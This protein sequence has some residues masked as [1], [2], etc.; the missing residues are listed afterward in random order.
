VCGIAGIWSN[1][2]A[3]ECKLLRQMTDSL[4]HRGPDG[5]G[6]WVSDDGSVGL[7]HR[8]LSIIDLSENGAQPMHYGE[9][10]VITFNGEIYNYLELKNELEQKGFIFK[11]ESDTEVLLAAY[12][13][14]GE[15]CLQHLDGMF[16]FAVYDKAKKELFCARDRFGEKPFYYTFYCGNFYFASEMKAFWAVGVPKIIK[17]S[18]VYNFL[19]NDMVENPNNQS[20]TFYENVFKLK[21]SSFFVYK[22]ID[23]QQKTY[24][25]IN[26]ED[27]EDIGFEE[28]AEKFRDLFN[29][30]VKR[31][32]RSDVQVGSSLS[33]GLDS[34]SVVCAVSKHS[35]TNHTFSARFRDFDKDEGKYIE[36]V[37]NFFHTNHHDVVVEASMLQANLKELLY[38]QEEPFPTGSIFA[39]FKV[40]EAARR[41]N[42]LVMLDG[43]GA[44]EFLCGYDKD[45]PLAAL[46]AFPNLT[47]VANIRKTILDNHCY[48]INIPK[49]NILIKYTPW[50][51]N[52]FRNFKDK[53]VGR[54][55][56]GINADFH[57]TYKSESSPFHQFGS[58][59]E[60]LRHELC[61]Q[62]LEK[63]LKFADRNSMAHSVEVR[64]P[65]LFHELVEFVFSLPESYLMHQGWSKAIL[66]Q[67]MNK[68]LP[69]DI[70]WRK[71]KIGFEAPT[72]KWSSDSI[73]Q[74]QVEEARRSLTSR[75]IITSGYT[76]DWKVLILEHFIS[77]N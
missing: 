38:H 51:Y 30:S 5:E 54:T 7:G 21:S 46:H 17:N 75:N 57:R 62:G 41:E 37:K 71:D 19:A 1:N 31:R 27:R 23:V 44:D 50:L 45:F 3:I 69:N 49:S 76:N 12:K 14:W 13:L 77:L 25:R 10:L 11:T 6:Q 35:A 48:N 20:E 42:I 68:E 4:V 73:I 29:L 28:A 43:Q 63:L 67:A 24:W 16:A 18:M 36:I 53:K 72:Q 34:S 64:L 52:S 66:R 2:S 56:E 65:F 47:Q 61:N 74:E 58:L 59:K 39:Q 40:Y 22:G 15:K 9:D 32:L 70:V 60:T 55:P 33:G 26:I 8:R